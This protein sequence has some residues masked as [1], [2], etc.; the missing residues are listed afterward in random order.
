MSN[1]SPKLLAAAIL[2]GANALAN[3]LTS[4]EAGAAA[5]VGSG[6]SSSGS[7]GGT[8]KGRGR[9]AKN[10]AP[11]PTAGDGLDDDDLDGDDLGGGNAGGSTGGDGLDD[12]DLD[13]PAAP[14]GPTEDDL[15]AALIKLK[16]LDG[17]NDR[18]QKICAKYVKPGTSALA[19]NVLAEHY[20]AAIDLTNKQIAKGKPAK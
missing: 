10:T 1:L 4:P 18:V 11:A 12:D 7:A 3:V 6:S 19:K 17:N 14:A 20:A 9:P 5:N 8:G 16:N 15:R 2:A 13:G